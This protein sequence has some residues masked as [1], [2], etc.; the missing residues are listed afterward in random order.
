MRIT[1]QMDMCPPPIN[2]LGASLELEYTLLST[3]Y[4]WHVLYMCLWLWQVSDTG[5]ASDT[6]DSLRFI[7]T[8]T[9]SGDPRESAWRT[10][11][12]KS[13]GYSWAHTPSFPLVPPGTSPWTGSLRM[14]RPTP[15]PLA[16]T[17]K[18]R[19]SRRAPRRASRACTW[20]PAARW[21]FV[22]TKLNSLK[23]KY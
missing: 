14:S 1:N 2:L 18:A 6:A 11:G 9:V 13:G 15:R 12:R 23:K 20:Q 22:R 7:E 5:P 16:A 8:D 3:V 21:I 10:R 4:A 17:W 19:G